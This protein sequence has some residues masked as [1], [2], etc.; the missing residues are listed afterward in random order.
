MARIYHCVVL[1]HWSLVLAQITSTSAVDPVYSE[2]EYPTLCGIIGG[3]G[4]AAS[5]NFFSGLVHRQEALFQTLKASVLA[6][7][8]GPGNVA[9]VRKV[10][11]APWNEAEVAR[12]VSFPHNIASANM[13]DQHHVPILLYDNPQI[14]D[15]TDYI[16]N[17]ILNLTKDDQ[18]HL[19]PRPFM[20]RTAKRLVAG[21][22]TCIGVTCNTAHFFL[23]NV[24]ANVPAGTKVLNMLQL[25]LQHIIR[26]F[27]TSA[28]KPI[29]VGLLATSGTI[30]SG[31]YSLQAKMV[32][33]ETRIELAIISPV[34]VTDG[35]QSAV[36]EAIYGV[37]GIKA[38]GVD[39]ATPDGKWNHDLLA[40]EAGKLSAA[41]CTAV[42]MG[43]TEIPL[44]LS[45]S[46]APPGT[47]VVNP[48]EALSDEV[49]RIT[50]QDRYLPARSSS[51]LVVTNV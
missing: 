8:D 29:K 15:R 28:G 41:G 27:P 16:L 1:A 11:T 7:A 51:E 3:L 43:C 19:D 47:Y 13:D 37:R 39:P 12:L 21:G 22:S 24:K 35:N 45:S 50:L 31:I 36:M 33:D 4:P 48:T 18:K 6:G 38:G 30:S 26:A 20:I 42:I 2:L 44:V 49:I 25:T 17:K 9:A 14:P 34:N 23:P 40:A 46:N 10:S 5:A 32:S